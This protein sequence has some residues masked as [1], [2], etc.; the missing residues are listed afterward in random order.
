MSADR[1][2]PT[3]APQV[4]IVHLTGPV[5]DALAAGDVVTAGATSPV[6]LTA[7]FAGPDWRSVW[8]R[9]SAQVRDD[10]SSAAWVTGVI[11]D[12]QREVAV[13]RAGYHGPP[14]PAGM[15][16]IG[17]AVDPAHR[18]RGYARAALESLLQRAA[19]DP[20]VRTVRVSISPDN[21]ASLALVDRYG[22]VQVGRQW[23]DEDGWETIFEI[24]AAIDGYSG[25]HR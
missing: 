23:D 5:F 22:F 13:G 16:E 12:E 24:D 17:Y 18:R 1:V 10:P 15:V 9:R 3:P 2:H 19:E 6:P 25:A 20:A 21:T 7:Y 14:D 4:R 8:R 11:W